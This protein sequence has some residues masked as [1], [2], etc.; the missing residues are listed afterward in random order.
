MQSTDRV[1]A[2]GMVIAERYRLIEPLGAGGMGA[3]WR[4][5]HLKLRSPVA[6]KLLNPAIA[7][8]A[9]MLERFLREAQ[10]AAALRSNYVVQVFDYGVHSGLPFIAMEVL[11]G[12][13]LGRKLASMRTLPA[14]DLAWIFA[15]VSRAVS[16]AHE[17]GIVHRD[18]KP[19]NIFIVQDGDEQ[20]AKVLDFGIAKVLP[21]SLPLE[22][23]NGQTTRTGT[24]LGTPF[25]MSP[26][27][28]R[29]NKTV[30]YRADL[31]SMGVI[32]Y[33]CLTGSL[34]F[35][36]SALGD[37]VV[38]ICTQPAPLPSSIGAVPTAF[39][40][41]FIRA[42]EKDPNRRFQ[43]MREQNDALQSV[44]GTTMAPLS[45]QRSTPR[46]QLANNTDLA[47]DFDA[48][49]TLESLPPPPPMDSAPG[50]DTQQ[51]ALNVGTDDSA[52]SLTPVVAA[53]VRPN[54]LIPALGFG[55]LVGL[56]LFAFARVNTRPVASKEYRTSENS[57]ANPS[58]DNA[59]LETSV[60][61]LET[62]VVLDAVSAS[63]FPSSAPSD[64][65]R[66]SESAPMDTATSSAKLPSQRP[67]NKLTAR[68]S[69]TTASHAVVASSSPSPRND[70]NL[71]Q[72][73]SASVSSPNL[74]LPAVSLSIVASSAAFAP[75]EAP[76][77]VDHPLH[78]PVAPSDEPPPAK[79]L[80][81]DRE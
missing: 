12:V 33:E 8:D 45:P 27:Q 16:K 62:N 11:S 14:R 46:G 3:V 72:T 76:P 44:L 47:V 43:S 58:E 38:K 57:P 55:A 39:D 48:F 37:L 53:P 22:E 67:G 49:Q 35:K 79:G 7:D 64:N 65:S 40:E 41:W 78:S 60:L 24:V 52:R 34:P 36:S 30:D 1:V 56:A 51:S 54:R 25:Y 19:D 23:D 66:T 70:M 29:G 28:A 73:V 26:E 61:A 10:A 69:L 59:A 31:W 32:A 5:E 4:A 81:D 77:S 6:V 71:S 17:L 18:L 15:H 50:G 80:F 74:T 13:S 21:S 42:C 68:S 20:L 2:S 9:E 75:V 63:T